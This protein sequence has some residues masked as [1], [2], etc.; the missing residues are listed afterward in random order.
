MTLE[1]VALLK[2]V[3]H[4]VSYTS[5]IVTF[6][7]ELLAIL[8]EMAEVEFKAALAI[9]QDAKD[10]KNPT[11]EISLAINS[12]RGAYVKFLETA[13]R[14]SVRTVLQDMKDKIVFNARWR[15]VEGYKKR[16]GLRC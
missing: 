3:N 5:S 13:E 8:Q 15:E 1:T 14:V 9:L 4:L 7:D 10:S 11:R 2:K 6:K 12:L 16:T